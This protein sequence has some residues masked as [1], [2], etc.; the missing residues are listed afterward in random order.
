MEAGR[1][2]GMPVALLLLKEGKIMKRYRKNTC[3]ICGK[4]LDIVL[5]GKGEVER[6]C[7]RCLV[8]MYPSLKDLAKLL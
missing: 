7:L 5:S 8:T 2:S 1:L 3:E 6:L 4:N